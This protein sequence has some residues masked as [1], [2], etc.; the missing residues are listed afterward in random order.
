MNPLQPQLKDTS[1]GSQ[2]SQPLCH[3]PLKASPSA[4]PPFLS[5]PAPPPTSTWSL[6]PWARRAHLCAAL[7][8][9][10]SCCTM[11]QRGCWEGG[12]LAPSF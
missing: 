6:C 5:H 3:T 12:S 7:E 9:L 1:C 8:T 2:L 10:D 11:G 4:Q